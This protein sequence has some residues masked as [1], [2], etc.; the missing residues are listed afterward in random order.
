MTI[1]E[2]NKLHLC[3]LYYFKEIKGITFGS[4][5]SGFGISVVGGKDVDKN[6]YPDV[7]TGAYISGQAVLLR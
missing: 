1:C 3:C 5:M 7:L 4:T 2:C 6:G